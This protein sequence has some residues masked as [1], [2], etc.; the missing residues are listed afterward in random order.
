VFLLQTRPASS[1]PPKTDAQ[2]SPSRRHRARPAGTRPRRAGHRSSSFVARP[3]RRVN[4]LQT[5]SARPG[6]ALGR[7]RCRLAGKRFDDDERSRIFIVAVV[8]RLDSIRLLQ[9]LHGTSVRAT[10]DAAIG[11]NVLVEVYEVPQQAKGDELV[12]ALDRGLIS[13][14]V[15]LRCSA[16]S[17]SVVPTLP[18]YGGHPGAGLR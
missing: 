9:A 16:S 7:R 18:G 15:S 4:A 3:R 12:G 13:R 10:R 14:S 11:H 2:R 6:S 1:S 17:C 5:A 8:I